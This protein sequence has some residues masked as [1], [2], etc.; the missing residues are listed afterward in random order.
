VDAK[1]TLYVTDSGLKIGKEG[2]E[3]TGTDG[4]W[5]IDAKKKLT[6]VA[7]G[8]D[9]NRPNGVAIAPDGKVWISV[10]G[11]AEIYSLGPKGEKKDV[12]SI[13]KGSLDGLAFLP[14]GDVLVSSWE[15]QTVYRG[16]PGGAF[17]ALVTDVKSPADFGW[18]S[19]RSRIMI[20]L[21]QADEIQVWD[22]K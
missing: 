7:K 22:V 5:T 9:L 3:P 10:F 12:T 11:A 2:F 15:S 13:P 4:V 1:G 6:N 14:G 18:D 21:F 19:K 20:P 8:K 17:T 16:K